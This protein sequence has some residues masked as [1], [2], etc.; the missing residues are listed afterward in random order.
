MDD[1]D[2]TGFSLE[3]SPLNQHKFQCRCGQTITQK[4]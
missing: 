4:E 2:E 1:I 3:D